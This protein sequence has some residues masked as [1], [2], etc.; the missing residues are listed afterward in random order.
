MQHGFF[1]P[2]KGYWQT[3]T[4]PA[5]KY[6]AAYPDGYVEVPLKPSQHHHYTGT[7]WVEVLP[8]DVDPLT[9]KAELETTRDG[10]AFSYSYKVVELPLDVAEKGVR[11]KRNA[12][13]AETD[14]VVPYYLER[15]Q[16]VPQEWV[17]YRQALRDITAQEGFPYSVTWPTKP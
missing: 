3:N 12:L 2:D 14:W 1:H 8:P 4:Y 15:G 16:A 13:L 17:D 9:H 5:A 10:D 11:A 6:R 7:D